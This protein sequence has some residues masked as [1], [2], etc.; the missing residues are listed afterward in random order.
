M[1]IEEAVLYEDSRGHFI[2]SDKSALI[3]HPSGDCFT[4]FSADGRKTRMLTKFAV[5][6]QGD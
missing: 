4:F 1:S 5:K 6:N 2:Y 3:L